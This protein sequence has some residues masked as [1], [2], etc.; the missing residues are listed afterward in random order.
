[1]D[2]FLQH[3]SSSFFWCVALEKSLPMECVYVDFFNK[4]AKEV[5]KKFTW[6]IKDFSSL[7]TERYHSDPVVIGDCK[8]YLFIDPKK[9]N[10][11]SL[12]MGLK[13]DSGSLPSGW[14]RYV[15]LLLFVARKKLGE[16]ELLKENHLWFD[17]KT[18]AWIFPTNV[19]ITKLIDEKEGY[20]VN[21]ELVIVAEVDVHEVIGT[22][23]CSEESEDEN[24]SMSEVKPCDTL[25][26]T[27]ESIDVNGFKVLPSQ[28]N[29]VK[30]IFEA[31]PD[32][33]VGFFSRN[34]HL[35]KTSMNFLLSLIETLCQSLQELS[36]GDL[37]DADTALTYL[38]DVGFKVD[39]LKSKLDEVKE[40]KE[41]E[42]CTLALLMKL[43]QFSDLDALVEQEEAEL[44]VTRT[45]LS[46]DDGSP[47]TEMAKQVGKKLTWV[48]KDLSYL[49]CVIYYSDPVLIDD[50]EWC[51]FIDLKEDNSNSLYMGLEVY[52]SKSLPCGWRRNVKLRLSVAKQYSGELALLSELN[53]WFDKKSPGWGFPTNVPL[54]ELL[55]EKEGFQ[56][57]GELMIVAEVDVHE[58][59]GTFDC[60]E[61]SESAYE[62]QENIDVNGFQVLPSQVKKKTCRHPD[63]AVGFR[64]KNQHLRTTYMNFLLNLIKTLCQ[65][66]QGLSSKDLED[67]D[68][69]LTHLGDVGFEVGWLECKLDDMKEKKE[70]EQFSLA[71]L[72]EMDDS[73]LKLKQKCSDLDALVEKEE[74]ELSSMRA[75][76]SFDDVV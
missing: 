73:L 50:C 57:N 44:S 11:D 31:H 33:A 58:V 20:L 6:V 56:V 60:F 54:T 3:Q 38:K 29:S 62:S 72:R 74:A 30:R 67:A 4:M 34:Q 18:L 26:Q 17:Q 22:Y 71:L 69:A 15:K 64:S 13:V 8:W 16:L 19:P 7:E 46:F 61:E 76:M 10:V 35:R 24:A 5:G 48:V 47:L 66:L 37:V 12:Y 41:K 65:S 70:K 63:F 25:S 75:P 68:T 45:P 42:E 23:D 40:K 9:E 36:K 52:N 43:K 27:Q 55:D 28:V 14:R 21:G 2:G 51:L 32:I 49:P 59:I 53:L 1:M 39:W